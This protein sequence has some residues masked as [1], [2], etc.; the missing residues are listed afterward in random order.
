MKTIILT[1]VT[2]LFAFS[3]QAQ[4]PI[5]QDSSA[6]N[7]QQIKRIHMCSSFSED[8]AP[9]IVIDGVVADDNTLKNLD[10]DLIASIEVLKDEEDLAIYDG[11]AKNGAIFVITKF[12]F[13]PEIKEKELA[14]KVRKVEN[15]NWVSQQDVYNAIRAQVPNISI[16]TNGNVNRTPVIR[17]RGDDN[18]IVIVDGIRRDVSFL[19]TINPTDI[20]DIKVSNSASALNHFISN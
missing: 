18:T 20:E 8:D 5:E 3:L 1:A 17:M 12:G 14:F 16:V 10:P 6:I 7:H 11:A 19:N 13:E 4:I 2:F 9:L 15:V